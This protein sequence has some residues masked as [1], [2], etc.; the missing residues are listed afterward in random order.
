MC[1]FLW[2]SSEDVQV[3]FCA[4]GP[5]SHNAVAGP[6]SAT[7]DDGEEDDE[8]DEYDED[9]GNDGVGST[10]P[11]EKKNLEVSRLSNQVFLVTLGLPYHI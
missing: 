10:I 5:S 4:P 6:S 1:C 7:Y 11:T 2:R 3:D 9:D 8:D